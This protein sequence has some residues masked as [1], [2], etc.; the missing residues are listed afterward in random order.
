MSNDTLQIAGVGGDA[1]V[2]HREINFTFFLLYILNLS[3]FSHKLIPFLKGF[4]KHSLKC[5]LES[6]YLL[7]F[8]IFISMTLNCYFVTLWKVLYSLTNRNNC[9]FQEENEQN[10]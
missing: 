9:L 3:A 6:R 1:S 4:H 5:F 10:I 2:L 8:F 7:L